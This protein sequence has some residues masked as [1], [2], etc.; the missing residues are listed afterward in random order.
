MKGIRTAFSLI[1]F[2]GC[3]SGTSFGQTI[4]KGK[5][6]DDRGKAI[7]GANVYIKNSYDGTSS[8]ADGTYSFNTTEKGKHILVVNYITFEPFE[9][10]IT[11]SGKQMEIYIRLEES[12][13]RL[14]A[15]TISAGMF[16]AGDEKKAVILTSM[17]IM[18]TAGAGADIIS[19]MSTMPGA[20][21][22][23]G[24]TG[25]Y[26][27]GGEGREAQTFI[28]GMRVARPFYSNVPD[29]SSR[30]RFNPILFQG[31]YFST[32]GYS[33]EYGQGLSSALILNS[34]DLP[35]ASYTQIS[36][37]SIGAGIGHNHRWKNTSIGL[38]ANYSNM[39]PATKIMKQNFDWTNAATGYDASFMFRQKTSKTGLLKAY[40]QFDEGGVAY[41]RIDLYNYPE[42]VNFNV[43]GNN[44]YSNISYKESLTD[45]LIFTSGYSY[46][47]NYDDITYGDFDM[48]VTDNV[49]VVKAKLKYLFGKLSSVKFGGEAQFMN[50]E[51]SVNQ[52]EKYYATFAE[53][54]LYLTKKLVFRIGL[55]G[56]YSHLLDKY[57]LA[58]RV[59]LAYKTGEKG[60]F[61]FA[62]GK[63]FQA[64]EREYLYNTGLT[65]Y[66]EASHYI[67][68]YQLLGDDRS[69]RI[70]S[71]YKVYDK[72]LLYV[73][74]LTVEG[75]GDAMGLDMFW[76][77]KKS[78]KNVDYWISYSYLDTKRKYLYY[79]EE[80]MPDYASKHSLS[81]VYKQFIP[82]LSSSISATYNFGSGRPYFN[83]NNPDFMSDMT[84]DYHNISISVSW[85]K[86][87]RKSFVV[88]ALS[89]SN[90][91]GFDN[92][93]GYHYTPDGMNQVVI[94]DP[95][96]R[97]FF[98]GIFI[99]LGRD[100]TEDF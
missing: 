4:I 99:S 68:N 36:L 63:F 41:N 81:L 83:P 90:I 40:V 38:F 24:Q 42:T 6:T 23:G 64:P 65:S 73:P 60:Q 71:Y 43:R 1:I 80:V 7:I 45:K 87:I 74:D 49:H 19:A 78:I 55:R 66:E 89:V 20:N 84:K 39:N 15:V 72:L 82:F 57:N 79:P 29:F 35:D 86:L 44:L 67:L 52:E 17:D 76:R 21:M 92:V 37:M 94:Q 5:I 93:Y 12:V 28:D 95:S 47:R 88:A 96:K 25:L 30:G 2:I 77:D 56:E 13:T 14:D 53:S 32:G 33:A 22:V 46:T 97:Y 34:L 27:R 75:Y 51:D 31:T 100:N 58:P 26:V 9:Q 18:T 59:S 54:D 3:L 62:Y 8:N 85:L 48:Q 70:E 50:Y 10:E 69:F 11:I 61:S 98:L 16:E 91:I